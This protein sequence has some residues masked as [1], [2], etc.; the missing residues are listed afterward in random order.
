MAVKPKNLSVS[1]LP[2][3]HVK[4]PEVGKALDEII[5]YINRNVTPK[6]GNK[7]S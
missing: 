3:I 2:K 1:T 6:Q 4:H 5:R 7:Q